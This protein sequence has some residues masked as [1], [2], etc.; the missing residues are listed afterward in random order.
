MSNDS[1]TCTTWENQGVWFGHIDEYPDYMTQGETFDELIE[2]L[3]DVYE[4]LT[5]GHVPSLPYNRKPMKLLKDEG[6]IF[7]LRLLGCVLL[8]HGGKHDWYENPRTNVYQPVLRCEKINEYLAD[9]IL[10]ML[11]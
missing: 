7:S 2:N 5:G 10:I 9:Y 11:C 1:R 3:I 6:I 4:G 8:R